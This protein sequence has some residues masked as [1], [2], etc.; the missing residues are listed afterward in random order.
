MKDEYETMHKLLAVYPQ[1]FPDSDTWFTY[2]MFKWALSF[3][4]Q[5]CFGWGLG[6]VALV[7]LADMLNNKQPERTT[8]WLCQK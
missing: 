8:F 1:F 5:R 2:D 6:T 4:H 3:V 7:P